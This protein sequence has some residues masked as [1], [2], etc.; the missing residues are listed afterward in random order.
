M[1]ALHG[2]RDHM[3][4]PAE[5]VTETMTQQYAV[6]VPYTVPVPPSDPAEADHGKRDAAVCGPGSLLR[7]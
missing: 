5:A 4:D 1:Q 6:Q 2:S 3:H 7:Q